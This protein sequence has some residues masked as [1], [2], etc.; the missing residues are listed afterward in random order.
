MTWGM[1]IIQ[2]VGMLRTPW[3]NMHQTT[4]NPGWEFLLNSTQAA[5]LLLTNISIPTNPCFWGCW[6]AWSLQADVYTKNF[7]HKSMHKR[8]LHLIP[9]SLL[10]Q[11][12]SLSSFFGTTSC[13][14]DFKTR[15][16]YINKDEKCYTHIFV[17]YIH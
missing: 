6:S 14:E 16:H 5:V 10:W 1:K 4:Q 13:K 11:R 2:F 15:F 12:I 8:P 3:G 7:Q 17:L 9:Q